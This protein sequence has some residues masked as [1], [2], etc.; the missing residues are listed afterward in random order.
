VPYDQQPVRE[1]VAGDR[2]L[3]EA[4]VDCWLDVALTK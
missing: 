4:K 1:W 3:S 2:D